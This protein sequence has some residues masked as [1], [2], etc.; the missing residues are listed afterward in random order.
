MCMQH[1]Q[2]IN[3]TEPSIRLKIPPEMIGR[4][5]E[6]RMEILDENGNPKHFS[7]IE[8]LYAYFNVTHLDFGKWKFIPDVE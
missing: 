3:V 6:V 2:I 8:E 4:P 7:T 1:T 5:I